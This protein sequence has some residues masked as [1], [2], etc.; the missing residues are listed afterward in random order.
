MARHATRSGGHGQLLT[1]LAEATRPSKQSFVRDALRNAGRHFLKRK[2][3]E[4]ESD[5]DD[6]Q[7]EHQ[8]QQEAPPSPFKAQDPSAR[9]TAG[10]SKGDTAYIAPARLLRKCKGRVMGYNNIS[11]H[12]DPS[13]RTQHLQVPEY[14]VMTEH[15]PNAQY[16]DDDEDEPSEDEIDETVAEDMKKLEENFT[17]I[18][19]K[20]RLI[21]RIGEGKPVPPDTL[22]TSR[23]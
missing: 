4:E 18:S 21:N 11:I 1:G 17:G 15:D 9:L 8:Q 5:T 22:D 20:Y 3:T 14:Q 23:C 19:M 10:A 13:A 7:E 6:E 12:E 16:S 2:R